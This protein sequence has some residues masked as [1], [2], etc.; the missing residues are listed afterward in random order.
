M[1]KLSAVLAASSVLMTGVASAQSLLSWD[2]AGVPSTNS[3]TATTIAENLDLS[4]GLNQLERVGV[5]GN[6]TT[7]SF[8]STGW[9]ITDT[10]DENDKYV[11]F[12]LRTSPGHEMTL[13]SLNS[14]VW[15]SNTAPK[16][17]RW[18]YRVGEGAFVLSDTFNLTSTVGTASRTWDFA[19]FTTSETVEFRFWAYGTVNITN[20]ISSTG[21]AIRV[22]GN[23]ISGSGIDLALSGSIA[24]IPEPST[25]LLL[26]LGIGLSA[27]AAGFSYLKKASS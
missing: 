15:G 13:T 7:S 26:I 17:A 3:L 23:S 22:P 27:G 5:T 12:T 1:K 18:G 20:G 14:V 9:N 19:D 11:N 10:F 24:V 8:S 2:V 4:S 21:G 6:A 25:S 16:T